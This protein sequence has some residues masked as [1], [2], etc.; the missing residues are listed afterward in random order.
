MDEMLYE[1]CEII[2]RDLEKS[3]D[4]IRKA[5]GE[6]SAGDVDYINKLTHSL[7]SVK[8]T[9]A[10]EEAENGYSREGSRYDGS[11]RGYHGGMSR[12]EGSYGRGSGAKRYANGQYAPHSRDDGNK[13]R[14]L[15]DLNGALMKAED[16]TVR[17]EIKRL[18][19]KVEGM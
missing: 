7:K 14:L 3:V 16:D 6:L 2:T 13:N 15:D 5:G 11:Y 17:R 18:V 12:D 10:M 4:K 1:L 9:I 19:E 8:T